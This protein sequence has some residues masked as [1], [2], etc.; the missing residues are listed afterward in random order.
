MAIHYVAARAVHMTIIKQ[1][2]ETL[3]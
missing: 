1:L 3:S 2:S